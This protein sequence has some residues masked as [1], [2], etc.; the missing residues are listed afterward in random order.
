[1]PGPR[2]SQQRFHCRLGCAT[3]V[4][5]DVERAD[6]ESARQRWRTDGPVQRHAA[7]AP[8]KRG[9]VAFSVG[10]RPSA[11][12]RD[13]ADIASTSRNATSKVPG[14]GR[15]ILDPPPNHL[16]PQQRS[17]VCIVYVY[18]GPYTVRSGW[19]LYTESLTDTAFDRT[20]KSGAQHVRWPITLAPAVP[21]S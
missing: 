10:L 7:L 8:A 6:D 12:S 9:R 18:S 15:G 19:A 1:M 11:W 21:F 2:R 4:E 17:E 16:T 5:Q 13:I 14:C 20:H 3:A